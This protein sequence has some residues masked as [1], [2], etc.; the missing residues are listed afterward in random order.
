MWGLSPVPL[1]WLREQ[2]MQSFLHRCDMRRADWQPLC[3]WGR[4]RGTGSLGVPQLVTASPVARQA[5]V[6]WIQERQTTLLLRPLSAFL[7]GLG[8]NLTAF[9]EWKSGRARIIV[10]LVIHLTNN[11]TN[12][13]SNVSRWDMNTHGW[14]CSVADLGPIPLF[15]I[16]I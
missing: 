12:V 9:L 13:E 6:F 7:G 4:K 11:K 15:S 3:T 1:N 2:T 8:A 10:L 5:T 16:A 14:V